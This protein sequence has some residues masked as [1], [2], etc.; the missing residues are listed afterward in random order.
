VP[1]VCQAIL[2]EAQEVITQL[3][4]RGVFARMLSSGRDKNTLEK[5]TKRLD[6]AMQDLQTDLLAVR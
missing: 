4:G 6:T 1:D 5:L 2:I 3:Q